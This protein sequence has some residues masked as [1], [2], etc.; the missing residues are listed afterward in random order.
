VSDMTPTHVSYFMGITHIV[1]IDTDT[2]TPYLFH[3]K[4]SINSNICFV[5]HAHLL[6]I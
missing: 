2:A 4:F 1:Q 5:N 3:L 6:N